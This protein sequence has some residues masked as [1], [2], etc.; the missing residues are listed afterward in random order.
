MPAWSCWPCSGSPTQLCGGVEE[1]VLP[2]K[3]IIAGK[4]QSS[5]LV[6]GL[7]VRPSHTVVAFLNL[8][9]Q[10]SQVRPDLT[11]RATE[12]RVAFPA[13]FLSCGVSA[14][15]LCLGAGKFL[16]CRWG[17]RWCGMSKGYRNSSAWDPRL[18]EESWSVAKH[19]ED[20]R[21]FL[22]RGS[23]F[24]FFQS[25]P[26]EQTQRGETGAWVNEQCRVINTWYKP[27]VLGP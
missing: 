17:E 24:S 10:L 20:L 26:S 21:V 7:E 15:V 12:T 18:E 4:S 8:K 9:Q 2:V 5:A 13:P 25:F 3:P 1:G 22:S 19:A 27:F 16:C 11:L 23:V 14:R 6:E